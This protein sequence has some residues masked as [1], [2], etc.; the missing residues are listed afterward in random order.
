MDAMS[1][2]GLKVTLQILG[3]NFYKNTKKKSLYSQKPLIFI[4][5]IS[6]VENHAT[7]GEIRE[8]LR[9]RSTLTGI[10]VFFT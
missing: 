2:L 9:L 8:L 10:A 3:Q 5:K 1:V 6:V 4:H 7:T